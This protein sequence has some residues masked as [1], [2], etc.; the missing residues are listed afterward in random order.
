MSEIPEPRFSHRVLQLWRGKLR[1]Y[2]RD[3]RPIA[4]VL[5]GIAVIVL[6]TIGYLDHNDG[7]PKPDPDF[8]VLDALYRAV[9]LFGLAGSVDPPVPLELNIAR[10]LGPLVFGYA[11]LQ[12]LLTLFRQEARLLMIR[13]TARDHNVVVGLGE[14]GFRVASLV[15][16]E[17]RHV[18]VVE[19]DPTNPR[20]PGMRERGVTVLIGDAT[21]D[22]ML[23][24]ARVQR[25]ARLLAVCG[26][27]STNLDVAD[28]AER[29]VKDRVPPLYALVHLD[30]D[31]LWSELAGAGI[32]T[33]NPA[34]RLEFFN[35][36]AVAARAMIDRHPPFA[37]KGPHPE[38][39]HVLVAGLEGVGRRLVLD[40]A[41]AWRA[42]RDRPDRRLLVTVA[43]AGAGRHVAALRAAHP[44]VDE[45]CYLLAKEDIRELPGRATATYVSLADEAKTLTTAFAL[46]SGT[47][48]GGPV[49]VAV[50]DC[51]SGV[52]HALSAEGRDVSG[53]EAFGI[54]NQLT[55]DVLDHGETEVLARAKHE[56][57]RRGEERRGKTEEENESMRLWD[58][59]PESLRESNRRF[60][61]GI[62]KK[63]AESG[64]IVVPAPLVDPDRPGF[65]FSEDQV[66]ELAKQE[67][68]RWCEDLK[69]D[70]W[71]L[72][73]GRKD[74][75][76]RLHPLLV[77]WDELSEDD[78]DRDRDPVR[79]IPAM[80]AQAG[81]RIERPSRPPDG[82]SPATRAGTATAPRA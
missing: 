33:D 12:A 29:I 47:G 45:L 55:P 82:R 35:L 26:Q 8:G 24:R 16:E 3:A 73:T 70:G 18:I 79:E 37:A 78:R 9:A 21:D 61:D 58:A 27:D 66:E 19:R 52:A 53:I 11:A 44:E 6:G 15:H 7:L 80:L 28:A 49:V 81:F 50:A 63:L 62:S 39:L 64:C 65:A 13:F 10:I 72:T 40:I 56:E 42:A 51:H 36:F 46:R 67:H 60:V 2:W 48:A 14:K 71:K 43:G 76:H 34:F 25:A 57:Y 23:K 68:D 32:G 54:L 5:A 31:D 74:P 41:R 38:G 69:R 59:L 30:D 1:P 17:G 20:I 75:R 22:E 77:P 4:V